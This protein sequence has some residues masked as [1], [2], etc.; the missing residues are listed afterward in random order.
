MHHDRAVPT[1]EHGFTCLLV[2]VSFFQTELCGPP[3]RR[4]DRRRNHLATVFDIDH[5]LGQLLDDLV[6]DIVGREPFE[7]AGALY[8]SR[9]NST[10]RSKRNAR[11]SARIRG[12]T[13]GYQVPS[14]L[15][16]ISNNKV[17]NAQGNDAYW[18][19]RGI[20]KQV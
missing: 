8:S 10:R 12:T 5:I 16:D 18:L 9:H 17:R 20:P 1:L 4:T 13:I 14:V 7:Y 11:G 6:R 3:R 15:I 2:A 19:Y